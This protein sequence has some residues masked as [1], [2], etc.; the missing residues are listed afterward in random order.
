MSNL[1]NH[2]LISL[3]EKNRAGKELIRQI[4]ALHFSVKMITK[5][6]SVR[7]N[8]L[9]FEGAGSASGLIIYQN[10]AQD[11]NSL[12]S[13]LQKSLDK[14]RFLIKD[15]IVDSSTLL[16]DVESYV[17]TAPPQKDLKPLVD[18]CFAVNEL[19]CVLEGWQNNCL[20]QTMIGHGG[21]R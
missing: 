18:M 16:R 17:L 1:C 19:V 21:D 12:N 20:K 14:A 2:W 8:S 15:F 9:F 13:D 4:R 7:D 3:E 11:A 10:S 6:V 5:L